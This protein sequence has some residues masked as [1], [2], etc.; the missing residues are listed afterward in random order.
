L[1]IVAERFGMRVVVVEELTI[2]EITS[3]PIIGLE[4]QL[5]YCCCWSQMK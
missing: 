5:I 3:A 1:V 4:K 2:R